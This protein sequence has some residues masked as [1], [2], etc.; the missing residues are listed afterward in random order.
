MT[1]WT[2]SIV[3]IEKLE[4]HPNADN[5]DIV[6]VMGDHPVITKSGEYKVGDLASYIC[7]DSIVP[8]IEQYSFLFPKAF[9]Q[10]YEDGIVKNKVVGLKYP[11]GSTPESKR[12]IKALRLRGIYSMGL[13]VPPIEGLLEGDSIVEALNLKKW[14]EDNED[15]IQGQARIRGANAETP[16]KHFNLPYYDIDSMRKYADLFIE[17][18]EVIVTEKLEGCNFAACHDGDRLWIKS[19][20]FYKKESDIDSWQ[21]A[22][23]NLDLKDKLI[24][25]PRL[26]F[27]GELIGLVKGFRYDT[28]VVDG[29]LISKVKFFDIYDTTKNRYLDYD[30]FKIICDDLNLE[31]VPVLYRGPWQ[32]KE[33]MFEFAEGKSTLNEKHI[34]EGMVAKP[35]ISRYESKLDGRMQ[36]KFVG[37]DYTL[38][39]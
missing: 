29:K 35:I 26:A 13:L 5:L 9:E 16:P 27:F 30:D 25:Y 17:N 1:A 2:P 4:K 28:E 34:R 32:N 7:I 37:K 39:K 12:V 6:N 10:Y 23:S 15:N 33:K 8:D 36:L 22:A 14:E 18:E 20:K 21:V 31:T 38:R 19:R 11:V 3:K 24:K